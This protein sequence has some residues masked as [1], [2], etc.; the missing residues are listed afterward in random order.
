MDRGC[1][2]LC[3]IFKTFMTNA[4]LQKGG[5]VIAW[6]NKYL[7]K[8]LNCSFKQSPIRIHAIYLQTLNTKVTEYTYIHIT[9]QGATGGSLNIV[10]FFLKMS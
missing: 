2:I 9:E 5:I 1:V 8:K 10:F 3:E 4:R 6:L 7:G